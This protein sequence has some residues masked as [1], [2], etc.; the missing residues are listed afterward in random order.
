MLFNSYVFI[1]LFLP[2]TVCVYYAARRWAGHAAALTVLAVASLVFYA[3]W[4]VRNVLLLGGS[5]LGNYAIGSRLE[6]NRSRALL[7]AGIVLNLAV[8]ALFK[9]ANFFLANLGA[10]S[11]GPM[12]VVALALPLGISFF[13]F[14]QITFL[15]DVMRGR[16]RPGSLLSYAVFVGFFPHLIAGPIVQHRDLGGQ[17]QDG[18]RRDDVW[19]NLSV[20]LSIF[21]VGLGKKVLLAD[22]FAP[23]ASGAF[24]AADR[25]ALLSG[26]AAW[27]GAL[28]YTLQIFFDFSGYSDMAIGLARM[29]GYQL[30]V[31]FD[32]PYR[33][34][35]IV[36][37]WRRWHISL[38]TFLRDYLYIPLGGNRYGEA[39]RLI[40]L[41]ITMLLGGL[42][43]GAGWT[44]VVWG[45][46]HGLYLCI[47]HLWSQ[48]VGQ[49]SGALRRVFGWSVTM[50]AVVLAW[51]FFR[52]KTFAGA[53]LML[54]AMAGAGR[55]A[56]G[57]N[58]AQIAWIA[59]GVS[60]IL[61]LPDTARFF[62][63]W[64]AEPDG[65]RGDLDQPGPLRWRPSAVWATL[66]A[67]CL[68]WSV[69][70]LAR[71][72]EFIYYQF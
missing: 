8:L 5:I 58:A 34:T 68:V 11:G 25:G 4:D 2:A 26:G 53:W 13:T 71:V 18:S 32:A 27:A 52:A 40:N 33:S 62:G 57:V 39:R 50:L 69:L 20:G 19:M 46:L 17:L 15:V 70:H 54:R 7:I 66:T 24:D 41:M 35:S 56:E 1:F 14:E 29:L 49:G 36:E 65:S 44:Y 6:A 37:F 10:L 63:K 47:A 42:W 16:T 38:S 3:W 9:Y 61:L 43:H 72:S 59:L 12:A 45:G 48:R 31:N 55:V 30:P 23:L 21:A 51:V 22:N 28:C 60:I 64:M 67:L